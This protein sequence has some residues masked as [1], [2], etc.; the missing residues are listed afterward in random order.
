[1]D[2][3]SKALIMAGA[4]LLAVAIVGLGMFLFGQATGVVN[5]SIGQIDALGVTGVNSTLQRYE[6]RNVRGSEII[7]LVNWIDAVNA[8]DAMPDDIT[9][10]GGT[11]IVNTRT[12]TVTCGKDADTGYINAVTIAAK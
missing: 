3:A 2:N 10:T 5:L 8:R 12:Y 1:M 9:V 4:I 6:G 11:G 7:E